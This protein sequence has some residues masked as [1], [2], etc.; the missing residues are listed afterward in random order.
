MGNLVR[1]VYN[2]YINLYIY[3]TSMVYYIL[4]FLAVG[5]E[6][7]TLRDPYVVLCLLPDEKNKV[8]SRTHRKT[9]H[10]T[11]NETF[12]F[13]VSTRISN[14][15]LSMI[16]CHL[17]DR[18]WYWRGLPMGLFSVLRFVGCT[19]RSLEESAAYVSLWRRQ[20]TGASYA[21]SR[22]R[23]SV[24]HWRHTGRRAL[25]RPRTKRSI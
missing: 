16:T 19:V 7:R 15:N 12:T 9:L 10:P 2:R 24:R 18:I 17:D 23:P 3:C 21:G 1:Y 13:H 20:T 14:L 6:Q 5:R 11:F 25:V 22:V 4:S 8:Q